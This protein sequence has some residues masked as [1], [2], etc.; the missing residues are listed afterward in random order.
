MRTNPLQ[1][2]LLTRCD[3]NE[4]G[5]SGLGTCQTIGKHKDNKRHVSI[6]RSTRVHCP[7][8]THKSLMEP[9]TLS[10]GFPLVRYSCFGGA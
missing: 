2:E 10:K 3:A 9:T 6:L 8:G 1:R 4:Q 7:S 5:Y